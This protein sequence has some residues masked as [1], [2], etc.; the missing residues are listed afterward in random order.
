MSNTLCL[1][2]TGRNADLAERILNF[3]IEPV[4]DGRRKSAKKTPKRASKKVRTVSKGSAHADGEV[5]EQK[6][7][8]TSIFTFSPSGKR[9][10]FVLEERRWLCLQ[11]WEESID[12]TFSFS[13]TETTQAKFVCLFL[14]RITW[15]HRNLLGNSAVSETHGEKKE[16]EQTSTPPDVPDQKDHHEEIITSE[17][18]D[19]PHNGGTLMEKTDQNEVTMETSISDVV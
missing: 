19:Q 2:C 16:N 17:E 11:T 3:L 5:T 9:S 6:A 4:D 8:V 13:I 1:P 7:S 18:T 15:S 14:T 12:E 10:I